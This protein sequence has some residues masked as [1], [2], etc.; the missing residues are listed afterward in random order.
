M[1]AS[2]AVHAGEPPRAVHDV[3]SLVYCLAYLAAGSLPWERKP[4]RRAAFM[5]RRML[6]DGCSTLLDSC[7][8]ERLTENVHAAATVE[9]LQAVWAEVQAA[10]EDGGSVDYDACLEALS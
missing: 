9:A 7:A 1:F 6:T 3:E 8:A 4:P 2:T 10:H 5:K